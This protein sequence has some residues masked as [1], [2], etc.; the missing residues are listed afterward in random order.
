MKSTFACAL[1]LSA[2]SY[3]SGVAEAIEHAQ[4]IDTSDYTFKWEERQAETGSYENT[5]KHKFSRKIDHQTRP[6]IGILSEPFRGQVSQMQNGAEADA[7][8]SDYSGFS[9]VPRTHVQFLEQAGVRVIPIDYTLEKEELDQLLSQVNGVYMPGDSHLA[10]T[11]ERY[12][13]TFVDVIMHSE[14]AATDN[15]IHFPVFMMGNSLQTYVR[16]RSKTR[17]SITDMTD[18]KHTN[19]RV[20]LVQHPEDTFLFHGM[21]VV[22][23]QAV[24]NTA[25]MFNLQV[26]GVT[27]DRLLHDTAI[28]G[29]LKPLAVFSSHDIEDEQDR[30]VAIAEG[31]EFPLYA[32]TYGVDLIQFYFENPTDTMDNFYLDHS[33]IARKHAQSIA[34]LI[35]Q[36]ARLCSNSFEVEDEV[37]EKLIR[38]ES[39]VQFSYSSTKIKQESM[40]VG[41]TEH[42]IYIL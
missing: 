25:Q 40:P 41:M 8:A 26:S 34:L 14:E 13:S 37:F 31:K 5:K 2:C 15:G 39:L 1:L 29:K 19:S 17:G 32:F 24:F 6:V 38:H 3:F 4:L 16:S 36:E 18:L 27:A 22:E 11:D 33:I 10:V 23:A 42:D 20:E 21:D 28:K 35:A 30:F 12:K 7:D 9:Y